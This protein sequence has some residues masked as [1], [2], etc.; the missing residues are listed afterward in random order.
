MARLSRCPRELEADMAGRSAG[1]GAGRADIAQTLAL[2]EAA[3]VEIRVEN[4][5]LV[6]AAAPP[7]SGI[8]RAIQTYLEGLGTENVVAFLSGTTKEERLRLSAIPPVNA[9]RVF[10]SRLVPI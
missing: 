1:G 9:R 8:A 4:G 7:K 3:D 6:V 5:A 10:R 2:A